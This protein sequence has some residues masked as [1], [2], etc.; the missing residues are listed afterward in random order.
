MSQKGFF[1]NVNFF[2]DLIKVSESLGSSEP[3]LVALI[4]Q[5]RKINSR[6]PAAVYIPFFDCKILLILI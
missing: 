5:L 2:N 6:L 3:K 1:S 4:A